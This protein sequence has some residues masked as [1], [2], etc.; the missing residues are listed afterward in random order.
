MRTVLLLSVLCVASRADAEDYDPLRLPRDAGANVVDF[1]V[2][3][4]KR[5]RDIPI[6][7]YLPS[8]D[9]DA[10]AA[11]V[12]I[13]SHG[14]GGSRA[15][16][17]FLGKHWAARG[18]AAVFVQHPGSDESVWKDQ[19]LARRLVAMQEAASAKNFLLRVRDVPVVLDQLTTWNDEQSHELSGRLN[20]KTVGMSGHSFGG[21]TTQALSGQSYGLGGMTLTDAR[22]KA[23]IVMSPSLPQRG[24]AKA[25]FGNVKVPWLLMTGTHDGGVIGNQTPE[26]RRGIFPL[27]PNGDKFELVLNNAE[28]SAFTERALPGEKQPRNPNHHRVILALSTACWDAYLN[29]DPAAKKWLTGDG[30]RSVMEVDDVWQF[31]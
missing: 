28:H 22:I 12:V 1:T 20:T 21:Q 24:D 8:K 5:E 3:D 23:A 25:A 16:S 30:P 27:L 19:P 10:K 7:V 9:R 29:D 6:R 11:A 2:N 31:K 18:Y 17:A 26:T 13:F 14:L 15:G 4:S